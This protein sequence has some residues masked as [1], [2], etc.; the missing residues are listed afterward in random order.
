MPQMMKRMNSIAAIV[1]ICVILIVVALLIGT[2]TRREQFTGATAPLP[3][4][5]V[6]LPPSTTAATPVPAAPVV[7]IKTSPN[8]NPENGIIAEI[9]AKM[10]KKYGI[11]SISDIGCGSCA[12]VPILMDKFPTISYKGY[13]N[14][15]ALVEQAK[16]TLAKYQTA[17]VQV[18]DP[19]SAL[20]VATDLVLSRNILQSLS[21]E[22]IRQ[23]LT[24]FSK[25]NCKF[26]ALGNYTHE[27]SDNRD[28]KTGASFLVNFEKEPFNM[29][30]A[31]AFPEGTTNRAIFF[32]TIT[33]MKGYVS[34][35]AFWKN[36]AGVTAK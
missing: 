33:Q 21:Y 16:K 32:Y 30:P 8:A 28:I 24:N 5:S 22:G 20:P 31:D 17:S 15:P 34:G 3:P 7:A 12:W 36:P 35:N 26:I 1:G 14:S 4:T 27:S 29:S 11:Q 18:A 13:E 25:F 10:I 9:V 2:F 6:P 19:T 23:M